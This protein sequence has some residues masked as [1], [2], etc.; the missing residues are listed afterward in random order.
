MKYWLL[1]NEV[2][3]E[4][5]NISKYYLKGNFSSIMKISMKELFNM[6]CVC[7]VLHCSVLL[8]QTLLWVKTTV[9]YENIDT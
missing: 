1:S 7:N 9:E 8:N 5:K 6:L 4:Y 3:D 2:N